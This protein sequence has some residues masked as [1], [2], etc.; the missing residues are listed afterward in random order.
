[1]REAFLA[2][3]REAFIP[4]VATERGLSVVYRDEAFPTKLDAGG[5]AISSSS[6][7]QIM[8]LMLEELRLSPGD[9]VLEIGA[10]TGYNAALLAHGTRFGPSDGGQR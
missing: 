1:V 3:P 4:S 5:G 9:R 8:A 6:Q 7:P 2:T 10:G